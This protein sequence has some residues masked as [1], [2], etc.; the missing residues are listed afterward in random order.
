MKI[1]TNNLTELNLEKTKRAILNHTDFV[2]VCKIRHQGRFEANAT[3]EL[4]SLSDEALSHV[5]LMAIE[6]PCERHVFTYFDV[7]AIYEPDIKELSDDGE[8]TSAEIYLL[9]TACAADAIPCI[10]DKELAEEY[11]WIKE[12]DEFI[13]VDDEVDSWTPYND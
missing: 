8:L 2:A 7:A 9:V 6:R 3:A 1:K 12:G 10:A 13:R 5:I 4:V 11:K